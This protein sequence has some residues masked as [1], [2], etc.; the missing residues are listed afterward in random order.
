MS[1]SKEYPQMFLPRRFLFGMLQVD[2]WELMWGK[3]KALIDIIIAD[4]PRVEYKKDKKES[5]PSQARIREVNEKWKSEHPDGAK[6]NLSEFL[7]FKK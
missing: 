6:V 2:E 3:S 7:G 1:L 4:R 5:K